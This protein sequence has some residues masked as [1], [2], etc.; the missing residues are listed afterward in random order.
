MFK[1]LTDEAQQQQLKL[2]QQLDLQEQLISLHEEWPSFDLLNR[3]HTWPFFAYTARIDGDRLVACEFE[4]DSS[5]RVTRHYFNFRDRF[6]TVKLPKYDTEL[7]L[8][9]SY[10]FLGRQYA[11]LLDKDHE[12]QLRSMPITSA[13]LSVLILTPFSVLLLTITVL[14]T[15]YYDCL[16]ALLT[17]PYKRVSR[18][19]TNPHIC[20]D[21]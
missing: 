20:L 10:Q 1:Q 13:D 14:L 21:C 9:D 6:L 2:E 8:R 5:R 18:L 15:I 19:L 3:R 7:D 16:P 4:R 12:P 17:K 11:Y